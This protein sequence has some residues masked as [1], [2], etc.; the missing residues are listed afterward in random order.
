MVCTQ[1]YLITVIVVFDRKS[2]YL[3][4]MNRVKNWLQWD[5]LEEGREDCYA[6]V[7]AICR[8]GDG[9]KCVYE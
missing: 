4:V 2:L 8:L 7:G 3:E 6:S 9:D 1:K 5:D